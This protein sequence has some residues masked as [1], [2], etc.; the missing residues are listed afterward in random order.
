MLESNPEWDLGGF[1]VIKF[2]ANNETVTMGLHSGAAN[3]FNVSTELN[4]MRSIKFLT[5]FLCSK[6][7]GKLCTERCSLL[8]SSGCQLW[9]PIRRCQLCCW[10][11]RLGLLDVFGRGEFS[12][13]FPLLFLLSKL[14]SFESRTAWTLG[15]NST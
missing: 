3:F 1:H 10:R 11:R 8:G 5:V 9:M 14:T 7:T 2:N 12:I 4:R 13:K 6:I 15:R